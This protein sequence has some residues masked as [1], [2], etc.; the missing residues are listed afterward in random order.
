MAVGIP[1]KS[2]ELAEP[3]ETTKPP[4]SEEPSNKASTS[5]GSHS[6]FEWGRPQALARQEQQDNLSS[7][8]PSGQEWTE[9]LA[10]KSAK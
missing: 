6:D 4:P 1:G 5:L 7:V 10:W 9:P 2:S 8:P 3:S